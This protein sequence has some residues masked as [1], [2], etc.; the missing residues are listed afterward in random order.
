MTHFVFKSSLVAALVSNY[1]IIKQKNALNLNPLCPPLC[2]PQ[3]ICQGPPWAQKSHL[4]LV[5][6]LVTDSYTVI[7]YQHGLVQNGL[8]AHPC[9]ASVPMSL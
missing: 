5:T 3:Q 6:F 9:D 2:R 7:V 1:R 4:F 8:V